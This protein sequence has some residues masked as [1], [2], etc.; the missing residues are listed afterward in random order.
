MV[1]ILLL[2][3]HLLDGVAMRMFWRVKLEGGNDLPYSYLAQCLDC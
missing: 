2:V 3:E 1:L